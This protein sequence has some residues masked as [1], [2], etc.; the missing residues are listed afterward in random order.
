MISLKRI[1]K[2]LK[3]IWTRTSTELKQIRSS[4]LP[5]VL[6]TKLNK[7][8]ITFGKHDTLNVMNTDRYRYNSKWYYY[9]FSAINPAETFGILKIDNVFTTNKVNSLTSGSFMGSISSLVH[10][11]L[12]KSFILF[13][14]N[15]MVPWDNI[16]LVFD[17][18][19]VW[20]LLHSEEYNK[21]EL[22][23]VKDITLM[24]MPCKMDYI[25][26]QNTDSFGFFYNTLVDYLNNNT[27]YRDGKYYIHSPTLNTTWSY[28][29][30]IVNIGAWAYNQMKYY[31]F[32][33]LEEE[34]VKKLQNI[35]IN[36]DE[37][38]NTGSIISTLVTKYNLLDQDIPTDAESYAYA[39]GITRSDYDNYVSISFN[40][41]GIFDKDGERR[42][43]L[44]DNNI[45]TR[46]I[47]INENYI[48]DLS[49]IDSL[50]LRDNFLVFVDGK[51]D[52]DFEI[53]TS[54]N[55]I[56]LF[57]NPSNRDVSVILIYNKQLEDI[58]S[59]TDKFKKEYI[60]IKAREYFEAIIN[61]SDKLPNSVI[62]DNETIDAEID[63]S[64]YYK[65][66]DIN[67]DEEL[68]ISPKGYKSGITYPIESDNNEDSV[69][70]AQV[71]ETNKMIRNITTRAD[72][73]TE[74]NK[75]KNES[76]VVLINSKGTSK[77]TLNN[78]SSS[79]PISAQLE[80]TNELIR[81]ISAYSLGVDLVKSPRASDFIIFILKATTEQEEALDIISRL[82]EPLDFTFL[83][84]LTLDENI[85]KSIN[86]VIN[87]DV[88]LLNKLYHTSVDNITLTGEE[89]NNALVYKFM[90]E[91][92]R[93][94][95]IPRKAYSHHETYFMIF[96][97]GELFS[98]YY[99]TI[100]Y[101]NFFYIPLE[102]D[103]KFE[104][105]DIVEISYFKYVNNNE[106]RFYLSDW[107]IDQFKTNKFNA[108]FYN[109][110]IFS[111]FIK[112]NELK[113][114]AHYPREMIKYPTLITE[115]SEN[116]A[117]N[118]S[119]RD[120]EGNLCIKKEGLTHI[121][122]ENVKELIRSQTGEEIPDDIDQALDSLTPD[123]YEQVIKNNTYIVS[124]GINLFTKD[125]EV[126]RN[127][128]VATSSHK[129]VYQR[130]FV[131]YR[132]Y[133]IK[134]DRRFRYC[135]NPKHYLLFINGRRQR[136]DS[137]IV[138]IP[139]HTR[140]FND[141]YLYTS[142]F[143][144]KEDRVELF[145]LPYD[146]T[147][148]N[149]DDDRRYELKSNG[150]LEFPR[151]LLDVPLSKTLYLFF[152]NG[153]KIPSDK[154]IDVDSHTIRLAID[155]QTLHYPMITAVNVDTL[156]SVVEYMHDEEQDSAYD[157]LIK[158][159]KQR[160]N[161]YEIL[162]NMLGSF[163][164][165]TDYENDKLWMNVAKIAILNEV[166]RDWWVTSGYDYQDKDIVYDF[167][168][169]D[170]YER[171]ENGTL[172][173]PA[174][175]A[176]PDINI[177]KNDI[178]LLYLYTDPIDLLYEIGNTMGV[179]KFYWEYSQ[180]LN[181]PW[182]IIWQKIN[183][184]DIGNDTR[185]Y[186]TSNNGETHYRF[187]ANTSQQIITR[188]FD[189]DFVNATY[190]GTIDKDELQYYKMLPYYHIMDEI[191]AVIPND[192]VMPSRK[193]QELESG[194]DKYKEYITDHYTIVYGL[195]Y[196]DPDEEPINIWKDPSL[197]NIYNGEFV[198]VLPDE[199]IIRNIREKTW[200]DDAI[201]DR[202]VILSNVDA[203]ITDG[204]LVKDIDDIDSTIILPEEPNIVERDI[205]ILSD[206]FMAITNDDT[207]KAQFILVYEVNMEFPEY[208]P[209]TPKSDE[210][211]AV[212]DD[213]M[214]II[215]R[216]EYSDIN[217]L[218]PPVID[219]NGDVFRVDH[220][221]FLAEV[222][223]DSENGFNNTLSDITYDDLS[224]SENEFYDMDGIRIIDLE[225]EEIYSD[226][227]YKTK[228]YNLGADLK[229]YKNKRLYN[230]E[231]IPI[232]YMG[233]DV[234][235]YNDKT[236]IDNNTDYLYD[237]E[238]L[239]A[240]TTIYGPAR[241]N[242]LIIT[243]EDGEDLS[244]NVMILDLD[245]DEEIAINNTLINLLDDIDDSR[246]GEY[247][248]AFITDKV[249][250]G[251]LFTITNREKIKYSNNIL[252]LI[253]SISEISLEDIT[254]FVPKNN[255]Y[256]YM[257]SIA[258]LNY[259]A[260]NI[261][262][263]E[264]SFIAING[265]YY[266]VDASLL[267]YREIS[268][269]NT[270]FNTFDSR[271]YDLD[272]GIIY[273]TIYY[274]YLEEDY[275]SLFPFNNLNVLD[276]NADDT[277]DD[278]H[279][280]DISFYDSSSGQF[281]EGVL[282]RYL[283]GYK[284]D[285]DSVEYVTNDNKI[286]GLSY[287][288]QLIEY[289]IENGP[290]Q[291]NLELL[292]YDYIEEPSTNDYSTSDYIFNSNSFMAIYDNPN[293]VNVDNLLIHDLDNNSDFNDN[294]FI[295]TDAYTNEDLNNI[296]FRYLDDIHDDPDEYINLEYLDNSNS[297]RNLYADYLFK[298]ERYNIDN[299]TVLSEEY[300]YIIDSRISQAEINNNN[301]DILIN[302]TKG[303]DNN[304]LYH[305]TINNVFMTDA[306]TG[307]YIDEFNTVL[308]LT[309]NS[310]Y[311]YLDSKIIDKDEEHI[312]HANKDNLYNITYDTRFYIE[313]KLS[314]EDIILASSIDNF[315]YEFVNNVDRNISYKY[316]DL[317]DIS[318]NTFMA[319][320]G[321]YSLEYSLN[322][323]I[324][325]DADTGE[326]IDKVFVEDTNIE[327]LYYK[328]LEQY[329]DIKDKSD[330][331]SFD[332]ENSFVFR[333]LDYDT[334]FNKSYNNDFVLL[335]SLV[336]NITYEKIIEN[337]DFNNEAYVIN[338]DDFYS[339]ASADNNIDD[340]IIR[341][342][343]SGNRID[344]PN[345]YFIIDNDD[346]NYSSIFYRNID[347]PSYDNNWIMTNLDSDNVLIRHAKFNKYRNI[348][349]SEIN[350]V[351]ELLYTDEYV[352][353]SYDSYNTDKDISSLSN[354]D[355]L[356]ILD[357]ENNVYL[358]DD[359]FKLYDI[360]EE[361]YI[362][363]ESINDINFYDGLN[364]II[365]T[366]IINKYEEY[367]TIV[368]ND[369]I[370]ND[371]DIKNYII[372]LDSL[373]LD[374]IEEDNYEEYTIDDNNSVIELDDYIYLPAYNEEL[375]ITTDSIDNSMIVEPAYNE[376]NI[377]TYLTTYDIKSL[378]LFDVYNTIDDDNIQEYF[379]DP[380]KT[381][382]YIYI[383][384]NKYYM[385]N[386]NIE[387]EYETYDL[388][389]DVASY[390]I[391]KSN[392][393][394]LDSDN[395]Q[396]LSG[397]NFTYYIDT[398]SKYDLFNPTDEQF[399]A[400][401]DD[402]RTL[403]GLD[404]KLEYLEKPQID[405]D[406]DN[407]DYNI[408]NE[409]IIY[410]NGDSINT[411]L[412]IWSNVIND[413]NLILDPSSIDSDI[414][415]IPDY[416]EELTKEYPIGIDITEDG[417]IAIINGNEYDINE[418]SVWPYEYI[419]YDKIYT[420]N[421][422][423]FKAISDDNEY[424]DLDFIEDDL[425]YEINYPSL[426]IQIV[427]S[428]YF[429]AITDNNEYGG[430]SIYPS[431]RR[432][433][434][435]S[436]E[437]GID[438]E[439]TAAIDLSDGTNIDNIIYIMDEDIKEKPSI[440]F[441]N[442]I[443]YGIVDAISDSGDIISGG[444]WLNT[445]KPE[446]NRLTNLIIDVDEYEPLRVI[447]P[448]ENDR[449]SPENLWA[450]A[451]YDIKNVH[452]YDINK[453]GFGYTIKSDDGEFKFISDDHIGISANN[454]SNVNDI[455][456]Y[457]IEK[458]SNGLIDAIED[459]TAR[460][461]RNAKYIVD[462]TETRNTD[463]VIYDWNNDIKIITTDGKEIDNAKLENYDYSW[464][465]IHLAN[466]SSD[467]FKALDKDGNIFSNLT[468]IYDRSRPDIRYYYNEDNLPA[469]IR[470]LDKYLVPEPAYIDIKDYEIGN[471][472]YFVFACPKRL[473]YDDYHM[474][475]DFRFPDPYSD[476]IGEHCFED[477]NMPIYTNGI[478]AD[479]TEEQLT[480]AGNNKSA[481]YSIIR[482]MKMEYMGECMFTNNYGYSE[483]YMVWRTN[484]YFTRL[485]D[486]YGIDIGIKIGNYDNGMAK[487]Y[488]KTRDYS[489][490][491]NST[492]DDIQI[493][494]YF[495]ESD[496]DMSTNSKT[497][498]KP[499]I[500]GVKSNVTQ[501]PRELKTV[502]FGNPKATAHEAQL[503]KER[504]IFLLESTTTNKNKN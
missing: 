400:L 56:F 45:G 414:V 222:D 365:E 100:A 492:L 310:Y 11:D 330:F 271:G 16:E 111:K 348:L 480:S 219:Y 358:N 82:M 250:H 260:V 64:T 261:D 473:V 321:D 179:I 389:T 421:N 407:H 349:A 73:N 237:H 464:S 391:N 76:T 4:Y 176:E 160:T 209:Y 1:R 234:E 294:T 296:V 29:N 168:Q 462:D 167:D 69:F 455:G 205:N 450:I 60:N 243:A 109:V 98:E 274:R 256:K 15:K 66:I 122:D 211:I 251:G 191:V 181:Q 283:D 121:L 214:R 39:Y 71:D 113:I 393:I 85:D 110:D 423:D 224:T 474:L 409:F 120:D 254:R 503:L 24:I 207:L 202:D 149:F 59:L 298:R 199:R 408:D 145:Y 108:S 471:Y 229:F 454:L 51:L 74:Y 501:K 460:V 502:V 18:D 347:D 363:G 248:Q 482:Q 472:N 293:K 367:S 401:L 276:Y 93:G 9:K 412:E 304:D 331:I 447:Y 426:D 309:N 499:K 103:F 27:E 437:E 273:D 158:Y 436:H 315:S 448:E 247:L 58:I 20:L 446:D 397:G 116:I 404:Y 416:I 221:T 379:Y 262:Y 159:I 278:F 43:Y 382:F 314:K 154:I 166:V 279:G 438:A 429:K 289:V 133:R 320:T 88:T 415:I 87:F 266:Y 341:D 177:V 17:C 470:N 190:W 425:S 230:E 223:G 128:L 90:Y 163:I 280:N 137:F 97:N 351:D 78:G 387:Y 477:S 188:D 345:K 500:A 61:S 440:N 467:D 67:V 284:E 418:Y 6:N 469:L 200:M 354:F 308:N 101:A 238:D 445:D 325:K 340:I 129:F 463:V 186:E 132:S 478:K 2:Y 491:L 282:F 40:N 134:L 194:N 241:I 96:V 169:D 329:N 147:D 72:I 23:K 63:E 334:K 299:L 488:N 95:K 126:L 216:I 136:Q 444:F 339:I 227:I 352:N 468:L 287:G 34:L 343:N 332:D 118:I 203:N 226:A 201:I 356:L 249:L 162:D 371:I 131:D 386:I 335:D 70:S 14:D 155:P 258:R 495:K 337:K 235:L 357:Y 344:D 106:I 359:E 244:N 178:S 336:D 172:L 333:G 395:N 77:S 42:Y 398:G 89:A 427:N 119:Y 487:F 497:N 57:P 184:K 459:G 385:D 79:T 50:I 297:Y 403:Y 35:T 31:S 419:D 342:I 490:I 239:L 208:G 86:S 360:E 3:S 197:V 362:I 369:Y 494:N 48:W 157:A 138:T 394:I 338:N 481:L 91:S 171:L 206:S 430:L 112:S 142:V 411:N 204:R 504:G 270:I 311:K 185:Y 432:K 151:E 366:E 364:A 303:I 373:E 380:E 458:Q 104:D 402:A 117:F 422:N 255:N 135:D 306:N 300:Q 114:F 275:G 361:D 323:I 312:V 215:R 12:I 372:T 124:K 54:V 127:A 479:V 313:S 228:Y 498:I 420:I 213:E 413:T 30:T 210:L 350:Y 37:Y 26:K 236:D 324:I 22:D 68:D 461:L 28:N 81:N 65:N 105:D 152:I 62:D 475:T 33:M 187:Q 392:I 36:I 489:G 252:E 383:D 148:I 225:T 441:Y 47:N 290:H 353:S 198:A 196:R 5:V 377:D 439:Y 327:S 232:N 493:T 173:L 125:K 286:R 268:S 277:P 328:Y 144:G 41:D 139:K 150:Y 46:S 130:L 466:I 291:E 193:Q 376:Y 281:I 302:Y 231:V 195:G 272:T 180:R 53:M 476:E 192:K 374:S 435:E 253:D 189:I 75:P 453:V 146:M 434:F 140:P 84:D 322:D 307:E 378:D 19:D 496:F 346:V 301:F 38:D 107:L 295:V 399:R 183:G 164:Q 143:V 123:V 153:K 457:D 156:D 55:N 217:L 388:S 375:I 456:F 83:D 242:D 465:N 32:G 485:I 141:L 406:V 13:L 161:G 257:S 80:D 263:P 326:I 10:Q 44:I 8:L 220:D 368:I 424:N 483:R 428:D 49:D 484:G 319:M 99:R 449:I 240:I 288:R 269:N 390:D 443:E 292:E 267:E 182:N 212:T 264:D 92:R 259:T 396:L 246:T 52:N 21:Y 265:S 25:S 115:E 442:E 316:N 410:N 405:I 174:L 355:D 417:F 486:N 452:S 433:W 7:S 165:M 305:Y 170:Y 381:S 233:L 451:D 431:N 218:N 102:D 94:L 285:P 317:Y 318:C 175:D 245:T 384:G 370:Y